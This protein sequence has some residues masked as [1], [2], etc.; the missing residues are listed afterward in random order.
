MLTLSGPHDFFDARDQAL[1]NFMKG[2]GLLALR[3]K[4]Q[5]FQKYAGERR[6]FAEV[7]VMRLVD[8]TELIDQGTGRVGSFQCLLGDGGKFLIENKENEVALVLRIVKERSKADVGTFCD[9]PK[10]GG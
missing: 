3:I 9:L 6:V 10:G 7:M 4:S 1:A 5:L 2:G 8:G